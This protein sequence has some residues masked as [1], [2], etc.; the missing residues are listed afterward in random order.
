MADIQPFRIAVPQISIDQLYQKL[1]LATFPDELSDSEWDYGTP[2]ADMKRLTEY[3]LEKYNWR[4]H[5]ER[6]NQIPQ[7]KTLIAVDGFGDLD[8]HF[9]HQKNSVNGAIPLLFV[10]GCKQTLFVEGVS[11]HS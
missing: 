6:L 3:W 9:A 7:F 11:G 8:I 5:E 2:L 10:H 1:A 4:I